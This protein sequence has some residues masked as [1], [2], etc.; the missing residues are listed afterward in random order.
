MFVELV[1]EGLEHGHDGRDGRWRL[2]GFIFATGVFDACHAKLVR[3]GSF[4]G[5]EGQEQER[6]ELRTRS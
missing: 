1:A 3:R 4:G 5:E 2:R 6:R